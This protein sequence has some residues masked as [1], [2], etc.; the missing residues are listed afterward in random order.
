MVRKFRLVFRRQGTKKEPAVLAEDVRPVEII[1]DKRLKINWVG[2]KKKREKEEEREFRFVRFPD[3]RYSFSFR[4][5]EIEKY[6]LVATDIKY[7]LIPRDVPP[8]QAMAYVWIHWDDKRDELIYEVVQPRLDDADRRNIEKIRIMLEDV[9]EIESINPENVDVSK[10]L[11]RKIS[12]IMEGLGISSEEKR[13][14]YSYYLR[15]EMLGYGKLEPIYRDPHI[16]DISCDG[17]GIPIYVYHRNPKFGTLRTNISFDSPEE[18]DEFVIKLA[19]KSGKTISIARPLLDEALPDGS[20]VQLTL[21]SDIAHKGSN[22]T[23]RKFT[24]KPMTP[25]D[26]ILNGTVD[27]PTVAY[28]WLAI[29][30]NSSILVSGGTGTGKTS[31]LNALSLFI[32]NQLK[33][34][35]IEDTP[36]LRLPHPHWVPEVARNLLETERG[37]VDMFDLLKESLRQRPD[38]IIVGEVRGKEASVLFQQIATGHPGLA[39]I[40]A[41]SFEK[42][43]DRLITPPINLSPSLIENLDM[44][45]F[46]KRLKYRNIYVR[47]LD[48]VHEVLFFDRKKSMPVT[49]IAIKWDA[50]EDAFEHKRSS[51][52]GKIVDR[53]GVS[54][55]ELRSEFQDRVSVID[56][57][58]SNKVTDY[59]RFSE[60]VNKYYTKKDLLLAELGL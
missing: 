34:V 26:L 56:W 16:E 58:V 57:M 18:L 7:S 41:D 33:V 24:E 8:S 23:I 51:I 25:T 12:E 6:D 10:Y 9:L 52:L 5:P 11:E 4:M 59:I 17:V 53:Y 44:V 48:M 36:E 1:I 20:R 29:E 49:N 31:M 3:A 2:E 45:I 38:Y 21:G 46:L 30:Y 47:R 39:T 22:F 43:V 15:N 50:M 35:S 32:K 40:H 37:K 28:L 14:K 19:E 13:R 55:S 27:I 54:E 60:I 42:L